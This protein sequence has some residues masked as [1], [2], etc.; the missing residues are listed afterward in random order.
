MARRPSVGAPVTEAEFQ[1]QVIDLARTLGWR[2]AHFRT[3]RVLRGNG[4]THYATPV[5]A[6]GAGFPD[7]I[8]VRGERLLAVELKSGRGVVTDEQLAWLDALEGTRAEVY[9]WR[10]DHWDTLVEVLR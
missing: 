5:Q 3:V 8:M 4:S 2:V 1:R 10:P 7:L 6:D 9:V